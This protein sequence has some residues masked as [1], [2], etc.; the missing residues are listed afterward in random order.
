MLP[1]QEGIQVDYINKNNSSVDNQFFVCNEIFTASNFSN[2]KT[3]PLLLEKKLQ[4]LDIN[5]TLNFSISHFK[6]HNISNFIIFDNN[7]KKHIDYVGPLDNIL[8]EMH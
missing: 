4:D 3:F 8:L 2:K 5:C 6:L 1:T 7:L